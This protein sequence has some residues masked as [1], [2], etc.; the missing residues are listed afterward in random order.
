MHNIPSSAHLGTDKMLAKVQQTFY[1][2]GIKSSFEKFCSECY[3]CAARKPYKTLQVPAWLCSRLA[4]FPH[5]NLSNEWLLISLA[6]FLVPVMV[7]RTSLL[8]VTV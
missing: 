6:L 8:F 5:L 4:L 7:I 2:P 1:W 3:S